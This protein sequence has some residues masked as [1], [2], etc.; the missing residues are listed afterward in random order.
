MINISF[1]KL[2]PNA[3]NVNRAS[4]ETKVYIFPS[5]SKQGTAQLKGWSTKHFQW[6]LLQQYFEPCAQINSM[7][8]FQ[9]Q[10]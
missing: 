4:M 7:I 3:S 1:R 5:Q 2:E 9:Y 8:F 6:Q 10:A